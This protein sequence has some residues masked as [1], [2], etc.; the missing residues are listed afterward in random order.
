MYIRNFHFIEKRRDAGFTCGLVRFSV[1]HLRLV[2]REVE[3]RTRR[4]GL[5]DRL[6]DADLRHRLLE[7]RRTDQH[8]DVRGHEPQ[9]AVPVCA[10]AV[11][12]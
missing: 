8:G 2:R 3:L 11:S 4:G 10:T 1:A 5:G 12:V 6:R 7:Q 9:G